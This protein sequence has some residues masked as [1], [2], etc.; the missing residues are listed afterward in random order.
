M[1][2]T[3]FP[4]AG[5]LLLSVA[6]AE[7]APAQLYNKT[8]VFTWSESIVEKGEDGRTYNTQAARERFAY[9][10]SAGRVF[11][12]ATTRVPGGQGNYENAP[13][14]SPPGTL[15][16]QGNN[17]MVGT[18]AFSGFARRITVTFDASFSS[19]NASVVYGRSGGPSK[20]KTPDG[21]RTLEMLSIS[22]G[23]VSCSIRDGNA[24]AQ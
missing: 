13:G 23:S 22:V 21:K 6:A 11:V 10:S 16:F 19:C 18:T 3:A 8:V 2:A 9:I 5:F 1:T 17:T 7:A 15:A 24:A 20:W 4:I 12:R 14:R